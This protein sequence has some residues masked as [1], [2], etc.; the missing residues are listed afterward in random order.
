MFKRR[1]FLVTFDPPEGGGI[2]GFDWYYDRTAADARFDALVAEDDG[3]R[4]REWWDFVPTN[5]T[6]NE[7]T[8][9]LEDAF[10]ENDPDGAPIRDNKEA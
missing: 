9:Y 1:V 7:V 2:G 4:V 10:I 3:Y 5:W 6:V 8:D